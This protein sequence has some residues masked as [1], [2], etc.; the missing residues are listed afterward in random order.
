[1]QGVTVCI[2]LASVG[3]SGRAMLDGRTFTCNVNGFK[4]TIAACVHND[5]TCCV[6]TSTYNVVFGGQ[7]IENGNEQMEYFPKHKHTDMYSKSKAVAEQIALESNGLSTASGNRLR[8]AVI[9]PA[10]IYGEHEQRHLPRIASLMD[11]GLYTFNVG[12][13]NAK[14]DWV[15]IDNLVQAYALLVQKLMEGDDAVQ[16][17]VYCIADG[18]PINNFVRSSW[19]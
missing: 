16:G 19:L 3:M 17:Q 11:M 13:P 5:V 2:H 4:N 12:S 10:G 8:T 14:V 1:M 7:V 9:R 18:E 6:Y 15:Y